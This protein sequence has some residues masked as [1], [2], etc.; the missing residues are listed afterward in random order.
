VFAVL[1]F[2]FYQLVYSFGEVSKL[3]IGFNIITALCNT[4]IGMFAR[5]E[6]LLKTTG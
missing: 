1:S 4:L 5:G 2:S 6:H 3:H